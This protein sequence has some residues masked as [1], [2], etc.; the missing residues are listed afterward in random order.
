MLWPWQNSKPVGRLA[1]SHRCHTYGMDQ[2]WSKHLEPRVRQKYPK[3]RLAWINDLPRNIDQIP[4]LLREL[5][6]IWSILS[7]VYVCEVTSDPWP[8]FIPTALLRGGNCAQ[9]SR[10]SSMWMSLAHW[11][12][13]D[14]KIV[15]DISSIY[16]IVFKHGDWISKLGIWNLSAQ[17]PW[18]FLSSPSKSSKK[19]WFSVCCPRSE[20]PGTP[21]HTKRPPPWRHRF[22]RPCWR[23]FP[24]RVVSAATSENLRLVS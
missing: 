15:E 23:C 12:Q 1:M 17:S 11:V 10:S 22:S 4:E 2:T 6:Q 14:W 8:S 19:G 21:S 18:F 3:I 24:R 20:T 16:R 7:G 9:S 13:V 5:G